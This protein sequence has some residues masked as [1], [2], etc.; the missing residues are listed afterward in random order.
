MIKIILVKTTHPGNI[1]AV[2][3]A[4][5]TMVLTK[6][7]LVQPRQ[8]PHST[9]TAMAAGAED[10]LENAIVVDTLEEAVGNSNLII[11][12]S[13][14]LREFSV[15]VIDPRTCAHMVAKEMTQVP[16]KIDVSLV[17]GCEQ[18]GLSNTELRHCHY[19][20]QI[21]CN[22]DYSSLNLAAAVQI[23]AYEIYIA[24]TTTTTQYPS[25]A[26][27]LPNANASAT[28][29]QMQGFYEHL[30]AML[31]NIGYLVPGEPKKTME[32]LHRLFN[33]TRLETVEVNMLRGIFNAI[34]KYK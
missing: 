25:S 21:P 24:R 11:G 33:R 26:P 4:M 17:F 5:K 19:Q 13:G 28:G 31:I 32:R 29:L 10:L 22:P 6:L 18:S 3:R 14:R 20:V 2:A 27:M 16:T 30:Q 34:S 8:F 9:A 15:P 12:T 1:G 23:M 7:Y